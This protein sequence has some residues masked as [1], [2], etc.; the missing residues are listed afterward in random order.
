MY[1]T[2]NDFKKVDKILNRLNKKKKLTNKDIILL[3][4]IR[5]NL[6]KTM[7]FSKQLGVS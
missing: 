1:L 3:D 2:V 4:K 7:K 5:N 6:L